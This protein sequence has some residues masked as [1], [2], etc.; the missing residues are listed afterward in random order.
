MSRIRKKIEKRA[1]KLLIQSGIFNVDDYDELNVIFYSMDYFGECD[2]INPWTYLYCL[3]VDSTIEFSETELNSGRYRIDRKHDNLS[4]IQA[5]TIFKKN[6][7]N[8]EQPH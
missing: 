3:A 2:E 1:A 6:Y 4:I 5:V 8:K 7:L